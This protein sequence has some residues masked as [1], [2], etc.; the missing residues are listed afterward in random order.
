MHSVCVCVCV[1]VLYITNYGSCSADLF[2]RGKL[3]ILIMCPEVSQELSMF[4]KLNYFQLS[5]T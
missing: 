5:Q 3:N 2:T 4:Q 1:C